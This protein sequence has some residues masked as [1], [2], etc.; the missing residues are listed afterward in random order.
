MA[1]L[2]PFK[3]KSIEYDSIEIPVGCC[4]AAIYIRCLQIFIQGVARSRYLES[5]WS[6]RKAQCL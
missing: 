5:L 1:L 3:A 4:K 2:L 6:F